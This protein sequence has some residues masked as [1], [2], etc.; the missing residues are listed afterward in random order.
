MVKGRRKISAFELLKQGGREAESLVLNE[1]SKMARNRDKANK[2]D[3]IRKKKGRKRAR[4]NAGRLLPRECLPYRRNDQ[5]PFRQQERLGNN[6]PLIRDLMPVDEIADGGL[7]FGDESMS[8][9]DVDLGE[10]TAEGDDVG[11]AGVE[12]ENELGHREGEEADGAADGRGE[13][14]GGD[15]NREGGRGHGDQD[16]FN[17]FQHTHGDTAEI[18]NELSTFLL[19][20]VSKARM[21]KAAAD[22]VYKKFFGL[23]EGVC[24]LKQSGSFFKTSTAAMGAAARSREIPT[25][26]TDVY[27]LGKDGKEELIESVQTLRKD[28]QGDHVVKRV[29]YIHMDDL[30]AHVRRCHG[31]ED[32][33]IFDE[34]DLGSDGVDPSKSSS[35]RC[36]VVALSF[37]GCG[38]PYPVKITQYNSCRGAKL[39]VESIFT[40]IV[41]ELREARVTLRRC[42]GDSKERKFA[43]NM[44]QCNAYRSCEFCEIKGILLA[45]RVAYPRIE[46]GEEEPRERTIE[47]VRRGA[48]ILKDLMDMGRNPKPAKGI[49][50]WTPLL[51]LHYFD[52]VDNYPPDVMHLICL[53]L[54]KKIFCML[55][56]DR[57][58]AGGEKIGSKGNRLRLAGIIN[59]S[60]KRLKLPS[61]CGKRARVVDLPKMKAKEW[62]L[63]AHFLFLG[64]AVSMM[65]EED[66]K[67]HRQILALFCFISRA[68]ALEEDEFQAL[69]EDEEE[70]SIDEAMGIF[71][72][73]YETEFGKAECTFN[74]HLMSHLVEQRRKNGP[75][76]EYSSWSYEALFCRL[77]RS[78]VSGTPH[79]SLQMLNNYYLADSFS[80]MCNTKKSI[81]VGGSTEKAD[82]GIVVSGGVFYRVCQ[83]SEQEDVFECYR[84]PTVPL[85]TSDL[86]L[87]LNWGKVGVASLENGKER[88][89]GGR[90]YI[91][92]EDISGKGLVYCGLIFSY[93]NSWLRTIN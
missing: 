34:V 81:I 66:T 56:S 31:A 11:E 86:N 43:K 47:D 48:A 7:H 25:V 90:V 13:E 82:D 57:D 14:G 4:I 85:D 33:A 61:D 92:R 27:R 54:A 24:R 44:V 64:I 53:G 22:D 21:S 58:R 38:V 49:K 83:L 6:Q 28:L 75:A 2:A 12:D 46:Q 72:Y 74:E 37:P 65:T 30:L 50:G 42:V 60:M 15:Q 87:N 41:D 89:P 23:A 93:N 8:S 70:V 91:S 16:N 59:E 20:M 17:H 78:Y 55:F 68:V 77:R 40:S 5:R 1:K 71:Q 73:F 63:F 45:G 84:I 36:H 3:K 67:G 39:D 62:H 9:E 76:L 29:S 52:L 51:D 32:T 79:E 19:E 10:D 26:T 80:H 18:Q 69:G 35:W 88:D